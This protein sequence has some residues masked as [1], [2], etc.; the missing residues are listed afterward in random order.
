MSLTLVKRASNGAALTAVQHDAN[1]SA[2]ETAVNTNTSGV[3]GAVTTSGLNAMFASQSGG[4][5]QIAWA[6][7]TT[8]KPSSRAFRVAKLSNQTVSSP[9]T[10]NVT[11]TS[12]TFDL[13]NGFGSSAFTVPTTGLWQINARLQV[14]LDS[15]SP[16]G[17]SII[18][19]LNKNGSSVESDFDGDDSST[20]ARTY[21]IN[22][23]LQLGAGDVLTL[24][25]DFDF[26]GTATWAVSTSNAVFSGF[27]V[28][29]AGDGTL[30]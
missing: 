25:V 14:E 26:T 30:A 6:N 23:L 20:G 11:L 3:A 22:T 27:Y 13:A 16:T 17:I 1:M 19:N 7:I 8:G 21:K 12:E 4:K 9:G 29:T 2:I 15:G 24:S 28:S 10:V 5:Q 18:M